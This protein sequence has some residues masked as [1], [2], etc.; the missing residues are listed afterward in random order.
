MIVYNVSIIRIG[1]SYPHLALFKFP[2]IIYSVGIYLSGMVSYNLIY[3]H[4]H[5]Q[6]IHKSI[7]ET[8]NVKVYTNLQYDLF[9]QP[10]SMSQ[11]QIHLNPTYILSKN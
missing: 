5:I 2:S 4:L 1:L 10:Q 6:H 3:F 11:S 7:S 9:F 8:V